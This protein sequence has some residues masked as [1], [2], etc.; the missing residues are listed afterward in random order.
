[1]D[2]QLKTF[3]ELFRKFSHFV[4]L[5]AFLS[6]HPQRIAKHDFFDLILADGTLQTAKV[7]A[8]ILALERLYALRGNA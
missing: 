4:R 6:A 8:I 3:A 1:M 2:G 7:G 5:R